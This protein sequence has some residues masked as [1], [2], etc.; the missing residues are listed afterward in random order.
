MVL[1]LQG[2]VKFNFISGNSELYLSLSLGANLVKLLLDPSPWACEI[3]QAG[4]DIDA[5]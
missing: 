2:K 4:K 1:T 5:S 3:C